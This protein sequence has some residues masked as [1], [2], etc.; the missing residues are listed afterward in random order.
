[1]S[2]FLIWLLTSTGSIAALM[3]F[4]RWGLRRWGDRSLISFCWCPGHK[5]WAKEEREIEADL[6]ATRIAQ[7][8]RELGIQEVER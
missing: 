6:R 5:A 3:L 4:R 2:G 7:L 8:E 1:M